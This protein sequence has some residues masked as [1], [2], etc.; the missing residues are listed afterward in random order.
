[1]TILIF[2]AVLSFLVL[3]HE[4][5]HYW[6]AKRQGIRVKE[7]GLGYPPR[8]LKLFKYKGTLFSLNLIPMGGF[9]QLE[10]EDGPENSSKKTITAKMRKKGEIPFYMASTRAKLFT[11]LAGILFN[12]I[13]A[14]L[15]FTYIFSRTGLPTSLEGQVRITEISENSPTAAAGIPVET[16]IVALKIGEDWQEVSQITQVQSLVNTHLGE[17]LVFRFQTDCRV[18]CRGEFIEKEIY[19]RNVG[20]RPEDQGAMGVR[21]SESFFEKKAWYL[22]PFY[23]VY[24]GVQE[25]LN[26]A[27]LILQALSALLV[28]LLAGKNVSAEVAGPVGIIHQASVYGFFEGGALSILSFAALISVNLAIM[29]LLPIPALDGA[30]AVFLLLERVF[31]K[32]KVQKISYYA[33]YFG[34]FLLIFLMVLISANDIRQIFI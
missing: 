28:N 20:E 26:L 4:F 10:G 24:Y 7:F 33:N 11:V 2:I 6:V 8:I 21:F 12:M 18:D 32:E 3:I 19:L 13:F 30:R 31:K 25:A 1:M 9:V 29:N 15:A 27:W 22:M 23:A 17:S 14:V 34:F 16:N 5:G